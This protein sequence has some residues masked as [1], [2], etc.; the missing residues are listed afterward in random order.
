MRSKHQRGLF[1]FEDRMREIGEKDPLNR[2][3]DVVDWEAFRDPIE[4]A[5]VAEPKG[6]GGGPRFDALIMFKTLVLQRLYHLSDAQTEFMIRDRLS[7]MRFV[8]VDLVGA[9]R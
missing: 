5:V 9:F 4:K 8:G 1:D 3:H 2:L 7:F 6:P